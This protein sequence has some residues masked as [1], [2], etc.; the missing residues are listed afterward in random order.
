MMIDITYLYYLWEKSTFQL[1]HKNAIWI[2]LV[3][4]LT[5]AAAWHLATILNKH[6]A[7]TKETKLAHKIA[8]GYI[9]CALALWLLSF[10]A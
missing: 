5:V 6:N 4:F 10:I 2:L 1:L 3:L 8:L 7:R 9:G